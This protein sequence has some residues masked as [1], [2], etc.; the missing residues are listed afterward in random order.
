MF[1]QVH[2]FVV[3]AR[4]AFDETLR[5]ILN[6]K[7]S[8][9]RVRAS[10]FVIHRDTYR[11]MPDLARFIARNLTFVDHVALMGL[12][13]VGFARSN[14]DAL[15]V[16]PLDY[17]DELLDAVTTLDRAGV[18]VSIY[19]HQLCTLGKQLWPFSRKS[20]SDWKNAYFEECAAC[21]ERETCGG[22]FA[23]SAV[24]RSRGICALPVNVDRD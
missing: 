9:V 22:F 21:R 13:L 1:R 16:D 14:V 2:D 18:A 24:R 8:G 11:G 23:S 6:L 4:G 3:Q 17:Q 15:W 20:V 19:N 12:E 10:R 5:G 7:R